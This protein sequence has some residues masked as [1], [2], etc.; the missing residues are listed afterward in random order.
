MKNKRIL[1]L[2]VCLLTLCGYGQVYGQEEAQQKDLDQIKVIDNSNLN[3]VSEENIQTQKNADTSY[4]KFNGDL[5][6]ILFPEN[7]YVNDIHNDSLISPNN[8]GKLIFDELSNYQKTEH[9]IGVS[10]SDVIIGNV[11]N[12]NLVIIRE[13][14]LIDW[15]K[16]DKETGKGR[17]DRTQKI[18]QD[19][20]PIAICEGMTQIKIDESEKVTIDARTFDDGSYDY[21][22]K[23]LTYRVSFFESFETVENPKNSLEFTNEMIGEHFLVKLRVLDERGNF[24][25]CISEVGVSE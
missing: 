2:F 23:N 15:K 22:S 18:H 20:R 8:T 12:G 11:Y 17:I 3:T 10:Y 6:Q 7:A 14:S 21:E 5:V 24:N 13:W 9:L 19:S 25:E 16:F 1:L 4:V